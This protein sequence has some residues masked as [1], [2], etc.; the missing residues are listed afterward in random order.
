MQSVQ[1]AKQSPCQAN[2]VTKLI[3]IK[4]TDQ[5]SQIRGRSYIGL[6]SA[7]SPDHFIDVLV[8]KSP[9]LD[10]TRMEVRG[11]MPVA[12]LAGGSLLYIGIAANLGIANKQ[13]DER[14]VITTF[15]SW[16]IDFTDLLATGG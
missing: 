14:D 4:Q 7:F 12:R 3:R 5:E 8:G 16:S 9:G 15:F 13:D 1:G 6:R 10:S 11:Q 2:H